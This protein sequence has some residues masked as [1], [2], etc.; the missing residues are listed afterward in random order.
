MLN[1]IARFFGTPR[2]RPHRPARTRPGVEALNDRVLPHAGFG[3]FAGAFGQAAL[4]RAADAGTGAA[5]FAGGGCH[6]HGAEQ[7]TLSASLS[8]G[9]GATGTATFS[10]VNG[11]LNVSVTGAAI[12]ST[13]NVTA[14][15]AT[16]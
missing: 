7:A 10:D 14:T 9:S 15:D 12:S 6:G 4:V 8:N 2:R 1:F 13:L 16:G 3:G 5:D 11:V